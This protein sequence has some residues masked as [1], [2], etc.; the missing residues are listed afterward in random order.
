MR[1]LHGIWL[2]AALYVWAEDSVLPAHGTGTHPFAC[3]GT[4]DANPP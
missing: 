1:V 4:E 2:E 3:Q